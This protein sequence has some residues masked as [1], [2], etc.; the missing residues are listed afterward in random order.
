[1]FKRTNDTQASE[2]KS[3]ESIKESIK[4]SK[5]KCF[6]II[7]IIGIVL[8]CLLNNTIGNNSS[9]LV[10][11]L[12]EAIPILTAL[13]A[14]WGIGLQIRNKNITEERQKWLTSLKLDVSKFMSILIKNY[15]RVDN[16]FD[17]LYYKIFFNLNKNDELIDS[18]IINRMNRIKENNI[19]CKTDIEI[20]KNDFSDMFKFEWERIKI[21]TG[22]RSYL[23]F[24]G[25]YSIK[26]KVRAL[27]NE[28]HRKMK[29]REQK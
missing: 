19:E 8:V 4:E 7:G 25:T 20:L 22:W 16:D 14:I 27:K 24:I 17:F 6:L 13:I 21:E 28:T 12:K 5:N 2:K 18:Q 26:K 10:S 1:M 3:K 23:P 9:S 15:I 11:L 29:N